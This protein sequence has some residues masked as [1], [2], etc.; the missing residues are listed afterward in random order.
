MHTHEEAKN[1]RAMS[2]SIQEYLSNADHCERMASEV[3]NDDIRCIYADLAKQWR[4]LVRQICNLE[5]KSGR[6]DHSLPDAV[7]DFWERSI[8]SRLSLTRPR[9]PSSF[10]AA[11]HQVFAI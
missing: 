3:S 11:S 8:R 6:P 1:L 2:P 4:R 10:I 9:L 5:Q 7:S